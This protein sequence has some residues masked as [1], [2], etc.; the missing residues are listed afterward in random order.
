VRAFTEALWTEL[1][2]SNIRLTTVHPGT[3]RSNVIRSSRMMDSHAQERAAKLQHKYGMPTD[4][5]AEKIIRAIEHN[6]LCV[7]VGA[8]ARI[9][10]MLK[11][12]FR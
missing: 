7:L 1:A 2:G 5:A 4:K 6:K 8:D 12:I 3:I 10:E 11:R 9:A